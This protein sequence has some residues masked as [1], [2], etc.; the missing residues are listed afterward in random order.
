MLVIGATIPR[1]SIIPSDPGYTALI[2]Q[3]AY[4]VAYLEGAV[5]FDLPRHRLPEPIL[6]TRDLMALT[7]GTIAKRLRKAAPE[8]DEP[9]RL[10]LET[11]AAALDDIATRR[12][13]VLHARPATTPEGVQRLLRD[14]TAAKSGSRDYLWIT[15]EFLAEQRLAIQEW[16][17]KI[18][19]VRPPLDQ[20]QVG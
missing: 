6:R 8:V 1:M 18:D 5:I 9:V 7:T 15:E 19:E 14:R 20:G 3:L 2:G 12:N 10:W 16:A 11:C 4:E 17:R 13:H